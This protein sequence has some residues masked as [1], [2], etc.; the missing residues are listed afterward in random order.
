MLSRKCSSA[1]HMDHSKPPIRLQ[2]EVDIVHRLE[3]HRLDFVSGFLHSRILRAILLVA[4]TKAKAATETW[5]ALGLRLILADICIV[6]QGRI[7]RFTRLTV[8]GHGARHV[9]QCH[10]GCK[11]IWISLGASQSRNHIAKCPLRNLKMTKNKWQVK[12]FPADFFNLYKGIERA[13]SKQKV[14]ILL[15]FHSKR[16]VL[17]IKH[18]VLLLKMKE[19]FVFQLFLKK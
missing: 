6:N 11:M 3:Y 12:L 19:N 8:A 15:A 4:A 10:H 5:F 16:Y 13:R 2:L 17:Q 7:N 1:V 18:L 9:L 14:W